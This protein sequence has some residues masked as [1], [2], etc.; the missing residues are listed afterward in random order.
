MEDLE[1]NRYKCIV[2]EI[3]KL[4]TGINRYLDG[5]SNSLDGMSYSDALKRVTYL[6]SLQRSTNKSVRAR[7]AATKE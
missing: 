2:S 3:N 7:Y 5:N 6:R 4:R 1:L